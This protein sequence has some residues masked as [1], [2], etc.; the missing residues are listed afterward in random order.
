MA[1]TEALKLKVRKK[2]H[3]SCC[4]CKAIGVEVHHIIPQEENG[5]DTEVSLIN[6]KTGQKTQLLFLGPGGSVEDALWLD[7]NNLVLMGIQDNGH[8]GKAATV[9]K[10][11]VP[12]KTFFLYELRDSVTA[13]QLIMGNWRDERLKGIVHQ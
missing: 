12:T 10:Y 6:P 3:L 13:V 1:F 11:N 8:K 7:K 5:P 4:L 2:A 9:W